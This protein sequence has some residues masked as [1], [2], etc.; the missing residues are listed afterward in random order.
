MSGREGLLGESA[1]DNLRK[2]RQ[3]S[4]GIYR[5]YPPESLSRGDHFVAGLS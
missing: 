5:H 3:V 1:P 4:P 2:D